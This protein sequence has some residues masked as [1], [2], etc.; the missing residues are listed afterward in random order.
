MIA[1]TDSEGETAHLPTVS[2]DY[3]GDKIPA[4]TRSLKAR[5]TSG[6][7]TGFDRDDIGL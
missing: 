2:Q 1:S 3:E 7:S 5:E 4:S 6:M